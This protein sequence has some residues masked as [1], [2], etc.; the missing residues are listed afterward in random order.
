MV[1]MEFISIFSLN[2]EYI[3]LSFNKIGMRVS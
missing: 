3:D 2:I 1:L